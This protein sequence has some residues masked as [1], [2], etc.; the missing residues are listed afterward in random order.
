MTGFSEDEILGRNMR[1]NI[2]KES[3]KNIVKT[4]SDVLKT[5]KPVQG[6]TIEV[7]NK[8]G[9]IVYVE[10]SISLIVD[11]FGRPEGFRGVVRDISKQRKV[12]KVLK[13]A[14]DTAERANESKSLSAFN[15]I[16]FVPHSEKS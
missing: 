13:K 9:K 3:F 10:V 15:N 11:T 1:K 14:K 2:K 16:L 5:K 4:Y 12:E 8:E 7:I 6:F